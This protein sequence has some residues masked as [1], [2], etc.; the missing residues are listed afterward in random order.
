LAEMG[1]GQY[2]GEMALLIDV[3]RTATAR[4]L[5]DSHL[6]VIDDATFRNLIRESREV[7]L[8]MLRKFSTRLK[9]SNT[10]LEDF[11]NLWTRLVIITHIL[12]QP[13]AV[14][15]DHITGLSRLTQKEP[16]EI[17]KLIHELADQHILIIKDHRFAQIAREKMWSLL[18][19]GALKKYF[20]GEGKNAFADTGQKDRESGSG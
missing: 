20:P 8:Y 11:T 6:A 3:R 7:A 12:D 16:D 9:N 19:P 5:E 18:D 4:A 15:E 14:L 10:A 13:Q 2:F 1:P 17:R